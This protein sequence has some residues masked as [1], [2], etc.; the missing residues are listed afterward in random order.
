MNCCAHHSRIWNRRLTN[1]PQISISMRGAWINTTGI[2]GNKLY[3][4][5]CCI[6]YWLDSMD[7]GD[8]FKESLKRLL[9]NYPSVDVTAMGFPE[10]WLKQPLWQSN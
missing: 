10:D 8:E 1:A 7:R 4:I 2:D 5:L 9:N 6:G 3:A